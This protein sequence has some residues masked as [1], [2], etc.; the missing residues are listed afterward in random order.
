[1]KTKMEILDDYNDATKAAR[2]VYYEAMDVA[3]DAARDAIDTALDKRDSAI[4]AASNICAGA[5]VE[6][7]ATGDAE[8]AAALEECYDVIKPARE[9]RDKAIAEMEAANEGTDQD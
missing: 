7:H 6:A 8:C 2:N 3:R 9:L 5:I 4:R 1:M